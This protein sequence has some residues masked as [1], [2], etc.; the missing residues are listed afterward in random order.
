MR[1]GPDVCARAHVAGKQRVSEPQD[2][3]VGA[4]VAVGRRRMGAKLPGMCGVA[5]HRPWVGG[6]IGPRV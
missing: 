6:R 1:R 5:Q 2:V 4:T 3:R